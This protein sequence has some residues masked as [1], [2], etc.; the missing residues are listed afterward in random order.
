MECTTQTLRNIHSSQYPMEFSSKSTM[1]QGTK[2]IL[3]KV[4]K[5]KS[6]PEFYQSDCSGINMD[7]N[8]DKGHRKHT[9]SWKLNNIPNERQM[10]QRRNQEWN[11]E[12]PRT[13]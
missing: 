3:T 2:K 4:E 8:S 10:N 11:L 13:E 1:F 6:Y 9:N 7:I 5:L 12:I